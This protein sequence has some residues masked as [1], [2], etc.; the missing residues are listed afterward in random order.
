MRFNHANRA[1]ITA[2]AILLTASAVQAQS[3]EVVTSG[4]NNPRGLAF[5][6]NGDLYVVGGRHRWHTCSSR[7]ADGTSLL[8]LDQCHHPY[9]PAARDDRDGGGRSAV[10]CASEWLLLRLVHTTSD[11]RGRA[12][13]T[14]QS[15]SAAIRTCDNRPSATREQAWP[16]WGSCFRT[17]PS[18]SQRTLAPMKPSTIRTRTYR[19]RTPTAS[20][21]SRGGVSLRMRA[22]TL[23]WR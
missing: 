13:F 18:G 14:S 19:T 4:L 3:F 10:P 6:P 7:W 17:V 21:S 1:G 23:C 5:A 9:R 8:W 2:C 11:S 15:G 12:T 20:W 16:G 22:R